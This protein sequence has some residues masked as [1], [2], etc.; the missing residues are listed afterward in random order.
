MN[1]LLLPNNDRKGKNQ[2]FFTAQPKK[3]PWG[4]GGGRRIGILLSDCQKATINDSSNRTRMKSTGASS[5][6][7]RLIFIVVAGKAFGEMFRR[8]RRL[9]FAIERAEMKTWMKISEFMQERGSHV[10]L[11]SC[12]V[13]QVCCGSIVR[14]TTNHTHANAWCRFTPVRGFCFQPKTRDRNARVCPPV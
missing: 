1:S 8:A 11:T 6:A 13:L 2:L 5:L 10:T 3:E 12:L 9:E 7:S 4:R 14:S